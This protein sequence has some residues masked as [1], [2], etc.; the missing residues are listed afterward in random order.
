MNI[1]KNIQR[2]MKILFLSSE[3]SPFLKSGGLADVAGALP[4]ALW[5]LAPGEIDIRV[6]TTG[7]GG[8]RNTSGI[9]FQKE[10]LFS[11]PGGKGDAEVFQ[12][13]SRRDPDDLRVTFLD[14]L[15]LFDRP[16][17]YGEDGVDYPDNFRRFVLWSYAIR[18]WMR[19]ES[20]HPDIVHGNDWQNRSFFWRFWSIGKRPEEIPGQCALFYDSQSGL[21]RAL[22]HGGSAT[23]RAFLRIMAIF[24]GSS[25]TEN[26]PSSKAASVAPT[27]S[28]PSVPPT[29]RRFC[30]NPSE[31]D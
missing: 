27:G 16:G 1:R 8:V 3:V 19:K 23:D 2:Q 4:G 14:P 22:S 31:K 24:P 28:R 20:F 13:G 5:R 12:S 15:R 17:L 9:S 18:E 7:F 26:L 6:L 25:S 30:P 21:Q 29:G 11:F 10:F